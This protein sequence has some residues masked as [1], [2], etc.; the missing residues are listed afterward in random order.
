MAKANNNLEALV[1]YAKNRMNKKNK[2][3][4]NVFVG[5]TGG[6]KT[7]SCSSYLGAID[8][9]FFDDIERVVFNPVDFIENVKVMKQGQSLMYE[10]AGYSLSAR[11]FMKAQNKMIG[12]V[13]QTFRHRNL[14]VAY[15]VPSMSFIEKQIRD[16]MHNIFD[17]KYIDQKNELAFGKC[18]KVDHNALYGTTNLTKYEFSTYGGG[19]HIIDN[20]GF[21]KPPSKWIN[22]YEK[23]KTEFTDTIFNEFI[24]ELSGNKVNK[25]E[26]NLLS[27]QADILVNIIP[28]LK[29]DYTW[30][31]LGDMSGV[32]PRTLQRWIETPALAEA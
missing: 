9:S 26:I 10:E 20:V 11:D 28:E 19:R 16:L 31:Q 22:E 18:W 21:P 25:K 17:M 3:S 24:D 12:I 13:N 14:C 23:V 6:G 5:E 32:S 4:L 27:K 2:N 7:Y 8:P 1:E 15:T 30:N 29:K